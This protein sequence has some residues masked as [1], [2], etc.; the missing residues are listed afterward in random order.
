[1]CTDLGNATFWACKGH[2]SLEIPP[3]IV[4]CTGPPQERLI[5]VLSW[6]KEEFHKVLSYTED[7]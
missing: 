7:L 1:M 2:C 5:S 6:R 4:S 3:N